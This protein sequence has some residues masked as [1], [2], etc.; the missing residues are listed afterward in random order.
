MKYFSRYIRLAAFLAGLSGGLAGCGRDYGFLYSS[1]LDGGTEEKKEKMN[2]KYHYDAFP[3]GSRA[4]YGA[5]SRPRDARPDV[6]VDVSLDSSLDARMDSSVPDLREDAGRADAGVRADGQA[7]DA[8]VPM[9]MQPERTIYLDGRVID[10]GIY[11]ADAAAV[12]D[13][14]PLDVGL[15]DHQLGPD[16]VIYPRDAVADRSLEVRADA[17]SDAPLC[18]GEAP[19]NTL[20]LGV[21]AGSRNACTP[22]GWREDYGS[23]SGYEPAEVSCDGQDNDCSGVIDDVVGREMLD[24][25]DRPDQN[26]LGN[27]ALGNPW[28]EYGTLD[29]W[30]I[31]SEAAVTSWVGGFG[32]NPR[33]SS[34]VEHRDSFSTL[35]E[36]RLE[37]ISGTGGSGMLTYSLN[38]SAGVVD[39]FSVRLAQNTLSAHAL[40]RDGVEVA[41]A[42]ELLQASTDYLLHTRYDGLDIQVWLWEKGTPKPR[43]PLLSAPADDVD[44][45]KGNLTLTGDLD[46]GEQATVLVRYIFDGCE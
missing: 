41:T 8:S 6:H 12:A 30:D 1:V 13:A 18:P 16:G 28:T 21:C 24:S 15:A 31:A 5:D 7:D 9:D 42:S 3:D 36:F 39:G 26:G 38:T 10:A 44:A 4:D 19:L 37:N 14:R 32:T 23:V 34:Y 2:G 25:F 17:G 35:L 20:Q 45:A 43:A 40:Y 46:T 27:N 33:A 11:V 29:D 22:E